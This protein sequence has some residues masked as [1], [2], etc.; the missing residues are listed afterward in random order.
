LEEYLPLWGSCPR[1]ERRAEERE[2]G[3]G[4]PVSK[5]SGIL[6]EGEVHLRRIFSL[7]SSLGEGRVLFP[8]SPLLWGGGG[9]CYSLMA[10]GKE[11]PLPLNEKERSWKGLPYFV[12]LSRREGSIFPLFP[13]GKT[14]LVFH[15]GNNSSA[16]FTSSNFVQ[17]IRRRPLPLKKGTTLGKGADIDDAGRKK[18]ERLALEREAKRKRESIMQDQSFD[19]KGGDLGKGKSSFNMGEDRRT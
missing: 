9:E 18:G 16:S 6:A 17:G 1:E 19:K 11:F 15:G 10:E 4:P 12:L 8:S 13:R 2:K 5:G 3:A 7:A 14:P